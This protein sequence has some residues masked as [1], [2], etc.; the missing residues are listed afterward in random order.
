MA[1]TVPITGK[2]AYTP[3]NGPYSLRVITVYAGHREEYKLLL[4]T[5]TDRSPL[6]LVIGLCQSPRGVRAPLGNRHRL[7]T[8]PLGDW[9]VSVTKRSTHSPR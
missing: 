8:A 5:G 7:V 9:S 2:S 1:S 4:V 6:L 3:L